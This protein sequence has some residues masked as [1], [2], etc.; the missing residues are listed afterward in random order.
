MTVAAQGFSGQCG[1]SVTHAL[2]ANGRHIGEL[3]YEVAH[4]DIALVKL[5]PNEKFVNI[6]FESKYTTEPVRLKQLVTAKTLERGDQIVLDSP[7]TGCIDG[8]MLGQAYQR[9]PTDDATEPE[10][11]WFLPPGFNM[12][13]NCGTNLQPGMCGSAIWT[14]EGD[15]VG[16]FRYA[17]EGGNRG[18]MKDWCAATAA[19]ELINRGFALVDT[20][21]QEV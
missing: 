8:T 19:D 13:Q 5:D 18:M 20:S 1:I 6:T 17:P 4:T 9:I 15:V 11:E 12:G 16:F 3:I 14:E 21:G 2:P 10:Q 7:D